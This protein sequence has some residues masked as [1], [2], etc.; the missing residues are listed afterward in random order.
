MSKILTILIFLVPISIIG[1]TAF[2]TDE[3]GKKKKRQKT[4]THQEQ[5]QATAAEETI[6][7][8]ENAPEE[9]TPGRVPEIKSQPVPIQQAQT[10]VPDLDDRTPFEN[11]EI[12]VEEG[13]IW[14]EPMQD[15]EFDEEFW[16]EVVPVSMELAMHI[17]RNILKL[18]A[19]AKG[20]DLDVMS[21]SRC[22][23]G[24]EQMVLQKPENGDPNFYGIIV[25]YIG[26]TDDIQCKFRVNGQTGQI[27]IS[28][29]K[30]GH[31]V[32]NSR[33]LNTPGESYVSVSTWLS[34]YMM[35]G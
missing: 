32:W 16:R 15:D 20:V 35:E 7:H 19:E 21:F 9:S 31:A 26:C 29:Q 12:I 13:D 34:E 5:A 2:T 3:G 22:P 10:K 8:A 27:G 18:I 1:L 28:T 6:S 17:E 33:D 25:E 30:A 11:A 14:G 23:S 24:M 4:E